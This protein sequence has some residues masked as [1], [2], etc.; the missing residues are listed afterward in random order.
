MVQ[1]LKSNLQPNINDTLMHSLSRDINCVAIHSQVCFHR[2]LFYNPVKLYWCITGLVGP[3]GSTN[4]SWC[5]VKLLSMFVSTHPVG[6]AHI[7]HL[8]RAQRHYR[9]PNGREG[10]PST[11]PPTLSPPT[12]PPPI[13]DACDITGVVKKLSQKPTVSITW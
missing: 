7:C 11:C 9:C 2:W 6:C 8:L 12:H 1:E 13:H 3:L 4:Q 10:P 5:G